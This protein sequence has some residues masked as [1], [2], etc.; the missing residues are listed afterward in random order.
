VSKFFASTVAPAILPPFS[1][2]TSPCT[3]PEVICACPQAV[4]A[5]HTASTSTKQAHINFFMFL[6]SNSAPTVSRALESLKGWRR[7][8]KIIAGRSLVR[9]SHKT[10]GQRLW[11]L[12]YC[13]SAANRATASPSHPANL[14]LRS[15]SCACLLCRPTKIAKTPE[16]T[17]PRATPAQWR[18]CG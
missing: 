14:C 8:T 1:S 15:R 2:S 6:P 10:Q 5:K 16:G 3:V 11:K 12:Q 13:H 7:L 18:S 9:E 17:L 4:E